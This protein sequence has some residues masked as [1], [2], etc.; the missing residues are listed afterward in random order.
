MGPARRFRFELAASGLEEVFSEG[1]I[2]QQ[3]L[4]IQKEWDRVGSPPR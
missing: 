4:W 1:F 3:K 2:A